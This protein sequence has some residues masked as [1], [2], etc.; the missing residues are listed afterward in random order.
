MQRNINS[1]INF[2]RSA[3]R[4]EI[5]ANVATAR[6]FDFISHKFNKLKLFLYN[7]FLE[8]FAKLRKATTYYLSVR[9]S[10]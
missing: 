3:V 4:K 7:K 10:A 2:V 6:K 9:P 1:H 5:M 8:A